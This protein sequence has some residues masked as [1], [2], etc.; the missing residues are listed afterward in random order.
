PLLK[1]LAEWE[2]HDAHGTVLTR[3]SAQEDVPAQRAH[4]VSLLRWAID[5]GER[6]VVYLRLSQ[7]DK[8]LSENVYED[9]FHIQP[10]PEHYPWDFDPLLGMRCYGGPHAQSSLRVLNTWYGRLARAVLPVY[11][12]AESILKG[13][14]TPPFLGQL[15]KRFYR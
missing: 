7:G 14:E 12:W 8:V 10:R 13:R 6:Y 9:P 3:G 2:L 1:C 15:L 5:P 4:R 11:D